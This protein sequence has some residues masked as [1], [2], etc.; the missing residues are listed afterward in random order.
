MIFVTVGEQLPFDR[1]IM[2]MDRWSAQ[3]GHKVFAQVGRSDCRPDHIEYKDF[4]D[5]TEFRARMEEARLIVAHAGMGTII[6]SLEL[7]KPIVVMPR[8]A[9]LGEHR[10]DHQVA[11]ANRFS[12]LCYVEVAHDEHELW[13]KLDEILLRIEQGPGE[14]KIIEPSPD[15]IRT[16]RDFILAGERNG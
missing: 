2:A 7:G 13:T 1:L 14:R 9:Q 8:K 3:T 11:T 6:T 16:I 4:L 10:N 12:A 15:L 5:Q